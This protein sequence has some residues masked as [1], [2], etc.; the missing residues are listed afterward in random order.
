MT[1][2]LSVT[3]LDFPTIKANLIAFM[4]QNPTFTDYDFEASGLSFLADVLAYNQHYLAALVNFQTNE[5]FMDTAVKR[6]SV[7]SHALALGYHAK[8]WQSAKAYL[9]L[10]INASSIYGTAP[11]LYVIR[12]GTGFSCS[13]NGQLYSFVTTKDVSAPADLNGNYTF[14]NVEIAEGTY[15][16][17]AWVVPIGDANF[18]SIPNP[19][20]DA[21]SIKVQTFSDATSLLATNWNLSSTLYDLDSSS[22]VFFTQDKASDLTDIYFG[23]GTLGATPD[24]GEVIRAEYITCNGAS[25]NGAKLFTPTGSVMNNND[26]NNYTTN[27]AITVVQQS[28]GGCDAESVESIK[29]NASKHFTVQNRAV[30]AYDY[31]SI[32]REGFNNVGAIKVWGGEDNVPAQ[33]NSVMIC[34]KPSTPFQDVLSSAEKNEIKTLLKG[35]SVMNIRPIFV[36]PEYINVVVNTKVTFN[37]SSLP[38]GASLTSAVNAALSAYSSTSLEQFNSPMLY[39]TLIAN[40][41]NASNAIT[42]NLTSIS[43]YK[44][45]VPKLRKN[46]TYQVNFTN[47]ISPVNG[48]ISSSMF[49]VLGIQDKVAITNIGSDVVL[50][51]TISSTGKEVVKSVVGTVDF[52]T[53]L[54]TLNA[55]NVIDFDNVDGGIKLAVIPAQNDVE[56]IQS[57]VVRI[58][59]ADVNAV[60]IAGA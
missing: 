20:V 38:S 16:S 41:N 59:P 54:I 55:I 2:M 17:F 18:Y 13:I 30:T 12:R 6:S 57:N 29:Y 9:N 31:A 24:A 45:I 60:L 35:T 25:G 33:Y 51:T 34:I 50:V 47:E 40:I 15:N 26:P 32:I 37:P 52:S 48:A 22:L 7:L 27:V 19:R 21:S 42:S 46:A 36:D 10:T 14:Y 8:G 1:N 58:L 5:M 53:G 39:S 23:N 49:N 11:S 44:L 28:L 4:R 43:L 3:S 56:A